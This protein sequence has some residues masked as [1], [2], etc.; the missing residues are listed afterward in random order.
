VSV[1]R[2]GTYD[3]GVDGGVE[4]ELLDRDKREERLG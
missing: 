4:R 1:F 3:M 2:G